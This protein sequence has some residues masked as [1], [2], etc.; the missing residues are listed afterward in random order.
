MRPCRHLCSWD[1]PA[2]GTVRSK[3]STGLPATAAAPGLA[4]CPWKLRGSG[5]PELLGPTVWRELCGENGQVEPRWL[6][7]AAGGADCSPPETAE[8]NRAS[9]LK[10]TLYYYIHIYTKESK[11]TG[12][13]RDEMLILF[14]CPCCTEWRETTFFFNKYSLEKVS[15]IDAEATVLCAVQ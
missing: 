1:P 13:F 2:P 6:R 10:L 4:S 12:L 11:E 8:L 9:C 14:H 3:S 7:A 15:T 5:V